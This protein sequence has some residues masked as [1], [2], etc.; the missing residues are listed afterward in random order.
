MAIFFGDDLDNT[1]NGTTAEDWIYGQNGNDTL[2]G[3]GGNDNISGGEGNDL[4]NSGTGDN[5]LHGWGGNDTLNGES[6]NDILNGGRGNDILTGG[7]GSNQFYFNT[8]LAEAGVDIITDFSISVNNKIVLDKTAFSALE[9]VENNPL[10]AADFSVINVAA[11]IENFVA[12]LK[13]NEIV[14]NRRTGSLFYN[15]N[16]N[17]LGFGAGGGKFATIADSPANLSNTDFHVTFNP[18]GRPDAS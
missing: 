1:I 3:N 18:W 17:W 11:G 8:Y 12:G 9:T 4:L 14:Y 5:S 10:T 6:G 16:N 13:Q 15:P 7:L 2:N